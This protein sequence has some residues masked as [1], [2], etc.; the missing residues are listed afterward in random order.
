M[1]VVNARFLT[2]KI[3]GVQR[4]AMEI[5]AEL[6]KLCPEITFLAPR[7]IIQEEFAEYLKVK[8][9]GKLTGH[10]WEQIELPGYLAKAGNPLLINFSGM[11]P[12]FYKNKLVTI[13]DLSFLRN[14][15]WFSRKY[16]YYYKFLYPVSVRNAIKIITSSE[17]SKSEI[18]DLLKIDERKIHKI[19]CSISSRF[20]DSASSKA[21]PPFDNYILAVSSIDPR[22]NFKNL[23][24]SFT[25]V[26][27]NDDLKLVIIGSENKVFG[28]PQFKKL[29]DYQRNII[30]MGY[31]PDDKLVNLY[32]HARLLVYPSLYEGFG[33]PPLEAMAC[34]CPAVVSDIG[35]V[36]EVCGDAAYYVNPCDV[37]DIAK[38]ITEILRNDVLRTKLIQRGYERLKLFDWNESA[39]ELMRLITEISH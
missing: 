27:T 34:G 28:E 23:I 11:A 6:K 30:F 9:C 24:L 19:S 22:K 13:H 33:I 29:K 15:K 36:R 4:Y 37:D 17:F 12:F 39:K 1:I 35:S 38:G 10:L 14:P 8:T 7:N 31:V 18:V 32:R 16:Y 2:Q 26:K 5:S 3:A 20:S 25:M 21:V